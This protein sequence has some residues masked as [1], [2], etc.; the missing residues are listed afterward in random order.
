VVVNDLAR[1]VVVQLDA[2]DD[3]VSGDERQNEDRADDP[4]KVPPTTRAR[5]TARVES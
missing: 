1:E 4:R 3:G 5:R 2:F